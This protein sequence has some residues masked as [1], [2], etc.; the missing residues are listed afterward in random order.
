MEN[1]L[2]FARRI[3]DAEASSPKRGTTFASDENAP[4]MLSFFKRWLI[5]T[6]AVWLAASIVP[7]YTY[8]TPG[9]FLAALVLGL[10]NAFVKPV[11]L[12]RWRSM[13]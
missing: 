10:L 7:G 11:A 6:V 1:P 4:R 9:L 12:L 2:V 5:T 3:R 8:T 13:P